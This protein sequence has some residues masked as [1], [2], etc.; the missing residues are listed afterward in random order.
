MT[1]TG[2]GGR[3]R[4]YTCSIKAR[5]GETGCKGHSIPMDKRDNL[6]ASRIGDRL[7]Q[8][9]RLEEVLASFLDRRQ[10]RAGVKPAAS[11]VRGSVPKW[12]RGWD[13]NPR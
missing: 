3:Y 9:K 6:V 1:A 5:E 10:E 11:G 2:K 13:S 8:P 7:L 12:R 4:S